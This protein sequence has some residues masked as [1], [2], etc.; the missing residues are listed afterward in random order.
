MWCVLPSG[1]TSAS[2]IWGAVSSVLG[3]LVG[4]IWVPDSVPAAGQD[5]RGHMLDS[6]FILCHKY[7]SPYYCVGFYRVPDSLQNVG[8]PKDA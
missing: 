8:R 1:S 4:Y 5:T 7:S 6:Y 3:C 2:C